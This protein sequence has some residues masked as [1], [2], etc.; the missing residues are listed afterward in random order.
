M[1]LF[2]NWFKS[3]EDKLLD[4][5]F[6]LKFTAKQ[7]ARTAAKCE[8]EEKQLKAKVKTAIQKGNIEGAKIH[9]TDSIRK[10]NENLNMLRL[11]SRLD[12]V[13]S[14]LETQHK[15]NMVNKNM[16]TIVKSLEASL[17]DNNLE[18]VSENMDTFERQ[19]ENLDV[20]TEFVEQAMGNT[21]AATTPPEDVA[22]LMQEVADENGLE[23]ASSMPEANQEALPEAPVAQK[24]GDE[25]SNRLAA[26]RAR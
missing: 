14:R 19:F 7:L 1:G 21:T 9:A 6:N 22:R 15:M 24:E 20:Q 18:K 23:F 17:K 8:K 10:K 25:L 2:N 26:L 11:A 12:G 16:S 5:I 4:Q 13:V 3:R